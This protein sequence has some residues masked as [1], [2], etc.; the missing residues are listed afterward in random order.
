M[1]SSTRRQDASKQSQEAIKRQIAQLQAQLLPE[2]EENVARKVPTKPKVAE[3]VTLAPA[4]PSPRKRRRVDP[5]FQQQTKSIPSLRQPNFQSASTTFSSDLAK[6]KAKK[7]KEKAEAEKYAPPA[8]SKLLSNLSAV[9]ARRTMDDEEAETVSRSTGFKEAPKVIPM[10][11]PAGLKRDERLALIEELEPGPYEHNPP[12]DDPLFEKF[13]PHSGINLASRSLSHEDLSDYLVGRYFLSPSRLYSCIRL[14]PDK[15]GYEVP[16]GGDWVTIAVIAERGPIKFTRAPIA[17]EKDEDDTKPDWRNKNKGK[18]AEPERKGKR[19]INYK[20][21]DFGARAGSSAT[22]GKAVIRGDAFLNLLLFEADRVEVVENADG[23]M[24]K[25][26]RGGSKGAYERFAEVKEGDVVAL[27]NPKVLKPF[28]KS[29]DKPHPVD[30]VLAVT[31]E[32][33]TSIIV[34]GRARDLGRCNARKQDGK[35]CGSWCD[36]RVSDICE[37]HVQVAV[38]RRRAAR[39]EFTAGTSGMTSTS[40]HKRNPAFDPQRQWGLKPDEPTGGSTYVISGHVVAGSSG[41]PRTLYAAENIGREGQAKAK[42][43]LEAKDADAALK[44]LLMRDKDGMKTVLAARAFAK[45]KEKEGGDGKGG[46]GKGK[47]KAGEDEQKKRKRAAVDDW[48]LLS[49]E[50][51]MMQEK[52]KTTAYSASIIKSLGFDP[53]LKP[54]Q[55]RVTHDGAQRKLEA[56]EAARSSRTEIVL[57]PRPGPR[58]RSGV[59]APKEG[60]SA[61]NLVSLDDS[62]DDLLVVAE[63]EAAKEEKPDEPMVDLDDL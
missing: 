61:K 31:P 55:K 14:L 50:E 19:F 15:Q 20:L 17:V 45:E 51:D 7:D 22:G 33:A 58:I 63:P 13:E 21:I 3:P 18:P 49:E 25:V 16:V 39:P 44:K 46:K 29:N 38:K 56:L 8:P 41:D 40:T 30:N 60:S 34:L 26:Y 59:V 28:Q 47:Q 12:S 62:D 52:S 6:A 27:L 35:I 37:F 48:D 2:T 24:E 5:K 42:R 4:T 9:T 10:K 23:G 54:G 53:S 1:L 57:G 43:K 32:S 36:K 11:E